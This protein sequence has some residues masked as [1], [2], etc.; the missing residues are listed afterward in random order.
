MMDN[1]LAASPATPARVKP[2]P[3]LLTSNDAHVD[4]GLM[5]CGLT[6]SLWQDFDIMDEAPSDVEPPAAC[7]P[8]P[9]PSPPTFRGAS[10]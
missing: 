9:R 1:P 2:K 3:S 6:S 4:A 10:S 8:P 5:G 7:A